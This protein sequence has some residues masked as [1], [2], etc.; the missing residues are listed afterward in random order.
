MKKI[1]V[2]GVILAVALALAAVVLADEAKAPAAKAAAKPAPK[3][4]AKPAP[5]MFDKA[6]KA[7]VMA[8]AAVS[9]KEFKIKAKSPK[10][11]LDKMFY[12][13]ENDANKKAF[14]AEP[15]KYN[16]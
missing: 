16:K 12:Y 4:D 3:A 8:T 5:K 11:E 1:V 9:G 13:F 2:F 15:T 14:D 7:G 6:Q 10:S